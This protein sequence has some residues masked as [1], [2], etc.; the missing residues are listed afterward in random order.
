MMTYKNTA[1][2]SKIHQIMLGMSMYGSSSV[3]Q[4]KTGKIPKGV[5]EKKHSKLIVASSGIILT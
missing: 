4:W 5:G 3:K 1:Y 2:E